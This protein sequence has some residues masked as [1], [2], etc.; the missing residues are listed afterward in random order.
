MIWSAHTVTR[1]IWLLS[2]Q[3]FSNRAKHY[4]SLTSRSCENTA[5]RNTNR[6]N[7]VNELGAC[8][9]QS[10]NLIVI[11]YKLKKVILQ[12]HCWILDTAHLSCWAGKNVELNVKCEILSIK[13]Q[14]CWLKQE[15]SVLV[16]DEIKLLERTPL[17]KHWG[18]EQSCGSHSSYGYGPR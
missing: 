6:L 12:G 18:T 8:Q 3:K 10:M 7:R 4:H 17:G 1:F 13:N 15:G 2:S 11:N 5:F 16:Y 14:R 9:N